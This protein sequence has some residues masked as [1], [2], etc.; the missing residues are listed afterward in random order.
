MKEFRNEE[1]VDE[2]LFLNWKE[3]VEHYGEYGQVLEGETAEQ[4]A[5]KALASGEIVV[6]DEGYYLFKTA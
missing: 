4:L 1:G 3:V 2:R 5:E 6:I